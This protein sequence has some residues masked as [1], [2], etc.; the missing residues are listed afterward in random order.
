MITKTTLMYFRVFLYNRH[1]WLMRTA[2]SCIYTQTHSFSTVLQTGPYRKLLIEV[3]CSMLQGTKALT[4]THIYI[5]KS[6]GVWVCV[7]V[8]V[9]H[10]MMIY[11][12]PVWLEVSGCGSV[13]IWGTLPSRPPTWWEPTASK[14]AEHQTEEVH[15]FHRFWFHF[16]NSLH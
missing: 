10:V 2:V 6:I 8:C 12:L 4:H 11:F 16:P 7:C 3:N 9:L 5:Y 14:C 15:A 13:S 1:L